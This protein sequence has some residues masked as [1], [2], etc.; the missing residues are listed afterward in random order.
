MSGDPEQEYFAD[1][2]TEDLL[3]ALSRIRWLFVI[4]RNSSFVF[5]GKAVDVNEVGR[6][7]GVRYVLEGSIR[8][9]GNRVRI[10]G[11]LIDAATGAHLWA[12][13][14][15]R[16]LT[17][18]FEMQDEIVQQVVAAL[19]PTLLNM[20]IARAR[21]KP[22]ESLA[23]YDLYLRALP[24]FHSFTEAG[25]RRAEAL[26]RDALGRDPRYADAWAAL[27]ECLTRMAIAGWMA[28]WDQASQQA[29]DAARN[30]I[31]A[32]PESGTGLAIAAV[33]LANLGGKLD[34]AV[35]IANKALRLHPNS[36]TVCANCG[37]VFLLGAEYDRALALFEA[38]RRM[39]PLDPR[40]YFTNAGTAGAYLFSR[41]FE[42]A[43]LW[44]RKT[45]DKWP[46]HPVSLRYRAAALA[47]LGRLEEARSVVSD[48]L[49]VQPNSS[50]SRSRKSSY[51]DQEMFRVYLEA[52]RIA[53]L[54][55]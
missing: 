12:E 17:D 36:S 50:L 53:G 28:D 54:P 15:D 33:T 19:E 43:E 1:G 14:Y 44:T 24:E 5:K 21:A 16:D 42:E 41:Q 29:C 20:E 27:A 2:I 11:Q 9:A 51:R 40:G 38:A 30:T 4:A 52:L 7:L 55:E 47:L 31:E 26:L 34:Q 49:K 10:S 8:K 23:A 3:T 39:S 48:V 46:S 13:R 32:D 22:T 6:R 37:W 45:L 25:F 35:E 18:I